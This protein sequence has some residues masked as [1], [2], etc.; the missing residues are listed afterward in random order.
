M[1]L[2]TANMVQQCLM[3]SKGG[4]SGTVADPKIIF[5]IAVEHEAAFIILAHNHPSGNLT[6]SSDDIK[7]T[8]KLIKAGRMMDLPVLDHLIIGGASYCSL[9]DDGYLN[10]K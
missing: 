6:P 3:I 8:E 9:A 10:I 4:R 1:I 7:V 5:K 2:N